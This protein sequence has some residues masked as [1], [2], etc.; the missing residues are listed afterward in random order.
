MIRAELLEILCC[1]ACVGAGA[2]C[3]CS[4]GKAGFCAGIV[5]ASIL[6]VMASP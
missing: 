3:L 4:I 5:G 6:F 1:P 2:V